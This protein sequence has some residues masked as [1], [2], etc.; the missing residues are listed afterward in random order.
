MKRF[1]FVD[2]SAWYAFADEGDE[3]HPEARQSF[4]SFLLEYRE[5]VS[6]NHVIGET[7][8][9]IRKRLSH[10]AAWQFLDRI[11]ESRRVTEIFVSEAQER[12][13]YLFLQKHSEQKFSFVD[14]SS[15]IVMKERGITDCFTFDRH[16]IAAG[17]N[18]LP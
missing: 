7:Y 6:T 9:T 13:A 3:R 16:F 12:K 2:T 11:R 15:F 4:R 1:L 18:I 8:T 10:A 14:G 5:V 17:F